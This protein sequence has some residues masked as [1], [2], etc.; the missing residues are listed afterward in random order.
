MYHAYEVSN[1]T[2]VFC[3]YSCQMKLFPVHNFS[4]KL[5]FYFLSFNLDWLR[6]REGS[7]WLVI[8][9]PRQWSPCFLLSLERK[10]LPLWEKLFLL[11]RLWRGGGLLWW[12]SRGWQSQ[13]IGGPSFLLLFSPFDSSILTGQSPSHLPSSSH[14][15]SAASWIQIQQKLSRKDF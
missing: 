4:C 15:A 13:E 5:I 6:P 11:G 8:F 1:K 3:T 2:W 14:T 10:T 7:G 9:L 12:S